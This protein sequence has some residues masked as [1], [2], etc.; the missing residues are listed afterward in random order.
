MTKLYL[1]ASLHAKLFWQWRQDLPLLKST[2]VR[3]P[4]GTLTVRGNVEAPAIQNHISVDYCIRSQ[5]V[6]SDSSTTW[7]AIIPPWRLPS[8]IIPSAG[9][10]AV[11]SIYLCRQ[12]LGD[13]QDHNCAG[14]DFEHY[15]LQVW[16]AVWKV[17][18][19]AQIL[20]VYRW[21]PSTRHCTWS[22]YL[23]LYLELKTCK[24]KLC[25]KKPIGIIYARSQM[26]LFIQIAKGL[27]QHCGNDFGW[28][29]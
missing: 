10:L 29:I 22:T 7:H 28:C 21:S 20:P 17:T 14:S 16:L 24:A 11:G 27:W 15:E 25:E 12:N 5:M 1:P 13:I 4:N 9:K 2:L 8:S 18:R 6:F 3:V 19:H 26:M 23:H